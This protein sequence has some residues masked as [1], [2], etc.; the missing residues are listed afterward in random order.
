MLSLNYL[1]V[2]SLF[3]IWLS[4]WVIRYRIKHRISLGHN[5][6]QFL[7][8]LIIAHANFSEYV[9]LTMLLIMAFDYLTGVTFYIHLLGLALI[10]ARVSHVIGIVYVRSPNIFRITGMVLTFACISLSAIGIL[11]TNS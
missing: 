1:A 4:L 5:G 3:Y 10:I 6:N 8:K 11:C 7:E 9:P 2:M